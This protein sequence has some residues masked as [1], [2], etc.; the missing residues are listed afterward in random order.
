MS[1]NTYKINNINLKGFKSIDSEGQDIPLGDINILLGA[2]GVGKSN[3]ISFFEMLKAITSGKFQNYIRS[4]GGA[5]TL[6]HY[7]GGNTSI[8]K[9]KMSFSETFYDK[10]HKARFYEFE[11]LKGIDNNLFLSK[12]LFDLTDNKDSNPKYF[13]FTNTSSE[14]KLFP[15]NN[16]DLPFD[17]FSCFDFI[18]AFTVFQFNDTSN[19]SKIRNTVYIND[20]RKL[21]SDGGNLAAF[22]YVMK[23]QKDS[24]QYYQRIVKYI[25]MAMPQFHDFEMLPSVMN[26]DQIKLDWFENNSEYLFGPHQISDGSLRFMALAT[27]LLQP[28]K[29]LPSL[30]ILDE[31]E[32]GLHPSAISL[33]ASM[34]KTASQ[35]C[36][37]IIA[38]QSTTLIDEFEAKDIIVV[39]RENDKS[40][41]KK[42]NITE[43]EEWLQRY[44]LSEIWEKNI[45]GGRP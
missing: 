36:Q 11:L 10:I 16:Y 29:S 31:P 24:I 1:S 37:I 3:L 17:A 27:L 34:V 41:F 6:L 20:G 42:L 8:I 7:G 35:H 14:T 4:I 43:M 21:H 12:E 38:T 15:P 39:E 23:N 25:K 30:I 44:S 22:L 28:P 32:L 40:I 13:E 5:N 26:K 18:N 19:E 2:N 33:L 9:A 45:I